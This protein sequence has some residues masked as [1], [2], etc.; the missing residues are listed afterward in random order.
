M[1]ER[2]ECFV[3]EFIFDLFNCFFQ[4]IFQQ[5]F[6]QCF[7]PSSCSG[8]TIYSFSKRT[9]EWKARIDQKHREKLEDKLA[10]EMQQ[11]C[12]FTP[13]I[14]EN[15]RKLVAKNAGKEGRSFQERTKASV[16]KFLSRQMSAPNYKQVYEER[17]LEQC[18]FKPQLHPK[19]RLYMD[20]MLERKK[21]LELDK[22]AAAGR[23]GGN[24]MGELELP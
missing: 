2:G 14:T 16:D 23:E 22:A 19:S 3:D 1:V 15:S 5:I 17:E 18:S 24:A 9:R 13:E 8:T 21:Q 12:S 6:H 7:S 4:K 20:K 11:N 10:S